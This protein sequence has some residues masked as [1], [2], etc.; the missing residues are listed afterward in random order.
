MTLIYIIV[1]LLMA[2]KRYQSDKFKKVCENKQIELDIRG[3]GG[4]I[5]LLALDF[6]VYKIF[7]T[8]RNFIG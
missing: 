3:S 1:I 5:I 7:A 6:S 4:T 2:S 8:I